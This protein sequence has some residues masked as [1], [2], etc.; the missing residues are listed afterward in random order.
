MSE[1]KQSN[2]EESSFVDLVRKVSEETGW[3]FLTAMRVM[4]GRFTG[5]ERKDVMETPNDLGKV[6]TD[7]SEDLKKN[8]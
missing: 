4:L 6:V 3:S 2:R 7:G 8:N 1:N 5:F